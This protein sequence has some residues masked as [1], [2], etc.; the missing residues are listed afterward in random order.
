MHSSL[1]QGIAMHQNNKKIDKSGIGGYNRKSI[2]NVTDI[3]GG[4]SGEGF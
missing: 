4:S 2:E 3:E 1:Q